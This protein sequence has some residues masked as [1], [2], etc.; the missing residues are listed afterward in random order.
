MHA[1]LS[2]SDASRIFEEIANAFPCSTSAL[3]W[4]KMQ[5]RVSDE[6]Q[7]QSARQGYFKLKKLPDETMGSSADRTWGLSSSLPETL[8]E[9]KIKPQVITTLPP[10]LQT[11]ALLAQS[12]LF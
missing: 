7:A 10:K 4:T 2:T 3:W 5:K 12:P 8:T 1:I 9:S 6:T 11:D